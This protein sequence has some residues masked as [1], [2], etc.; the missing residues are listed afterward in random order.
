MYYERLVNVHGDG[1]MVQGIKKRGR[2]YLN[3]KIG[4]FRIFNHNFTISYIKTALW[5]NVV[6]RSSSI[7]V[8][9]D[10]W[11]FVV[12]ARKCCSKF[13][14]SV[15]RKLPDC[16]IICQLPTDDMDSFLWR[17][18]DTGTVTGLVLLHRRIKAN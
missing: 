5:L 4:F 15:L 3:I 14:E 18:N 2:R 12:C 17:D 1:C 10:S 9:L 16:E 11:E 13:P 8:P 7:N 6:N